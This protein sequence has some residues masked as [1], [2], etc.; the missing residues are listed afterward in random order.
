MIVHGLRRG[1]PDMNQMERI[2]LGLNMLRFLSF[3]SELLYLNCLLDILAEIYGGHLDI[4]GKRFD[5]EK[6][7]IRVINS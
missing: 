7:I 2:C 4:S 5:L 1:I 3:I 6:W